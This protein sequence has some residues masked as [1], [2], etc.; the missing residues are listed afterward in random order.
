MP[1][2]KNGTEA[3]ITTQWIKQHSG[4]K[5]SEARRL[6]EE[7]G[8]RVTVAQHQLKT[9]GK[10]KLVTIDTE[11]WKCLDREELGRRKWR[12]PTKKIVHAAHSCYSFSKKKRSLF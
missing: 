2:G 11:L 7:Y 12:G 1:S 9:R 5:I 3:T 10:N 8:K 4:L 6:L